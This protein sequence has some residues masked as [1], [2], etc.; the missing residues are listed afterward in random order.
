MQLFAGLQET[1]EGWGRKAGDDDC[2]EFVR[3]REEGYWFPC[4]LLRSFARSSRSCRRPGDGGCGG[5]K[6]EGMLYHRCN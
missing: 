6:G 5:A 3:K 4:F 1:A 2:E